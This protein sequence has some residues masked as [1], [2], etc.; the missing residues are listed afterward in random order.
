M[1]RRRSRRWSSALLVRTSWKPGPQRGSR[2][3]VASRH[4][5]MDEEDRQRCARFCVEHR[6]QRAAVRVDD[7]GFLRRRQADA[8]RRLAARYTTA[9][10]RSAVHQPAGRSA[11]DF[12]DRSGGLHPARAFR[13]DE[14]LVSLLRRNGRVRSNRLGAAAVQHRREANS[15]P[16]PLDGR[17]GRVASRVAAPWKVCGD[18]VE[19]RVRRYLHSSARPHQAASTA[20]AASGGHAALLRRGRLRVERVQHADSWIHRRDRRKCRGIQDAR[21]VGEGR[22]PLH[23]GDTLPLD[24]DGS[25]RAVS[26]GTEDRSLMARRV[27]GRVGSLHQKSARR[28]G[29]QAAESR[30]VR[31][32]HDTVEQRTLGDCRGSGRNI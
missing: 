21:G 28:D 7:P 12:T 23:S 15:Y 10:Q 2:V 29:R 19:R 9:A 20:A 4:G 27:E 24:D 8:A 31:H 16:R 32:L 25:A 14:P 30:A 22:V 18:R 5:V 11:L 3:G 13:P 26:G 1:R 17:P 6:R